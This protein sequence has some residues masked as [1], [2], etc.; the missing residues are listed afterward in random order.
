[1]FHNLWVR[2]IKCAAIFIRNVSKHSV[3]ESVNRFCAVDICV[4]DM[5]IQL[6]G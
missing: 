1:M 5:D 6:S 3:L 2:D 4:F